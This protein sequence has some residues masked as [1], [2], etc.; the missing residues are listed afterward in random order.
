MQPPTLQARNTAQWGHFREPQQM[1]TSGLLR[2]P[3]EVTSPTQP[4]QSLRPYGGHP[5]PA[6]TWLISHR[7]CL[8]PAR[9][10]PSL[11]SD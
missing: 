2:G 8:T 7:F 4:L 9:P 5:G 1:P 6:P 11:Q 10:W 3:S